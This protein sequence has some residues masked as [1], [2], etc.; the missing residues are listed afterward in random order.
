M[1]KVEFTRRETVAALAAGAALPL[2]SDRAFAAP[3]VRATTD[4][5]PS[6]VLQ[7]FAEHLLQLS[8]ETA[9]S[10]GVDK[11]LRAPLRRRLGDRSPAGVQRTRA[12]IRADLARAEAI[13]ERNLSFTV[14]TSVDV[15]RQPKKRAP[16]NMAP[17]KPV[18][19][20]SPRITAGTR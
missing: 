16:R 15:V 18:V 4:A 3:A 11:G 5:E 17:V 2:L 6:A 10:L 8:P 12:T 7:S 19:R 1:S 13:D 20:N 9:T 14:R